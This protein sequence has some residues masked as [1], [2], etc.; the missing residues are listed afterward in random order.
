ML[1]IILVPVLGLVL[2]Y[3]I[4]R[5]FKNAKFKGYDILPFFFI[6]VCNTMTNLKDRPSFLPY[7]FFTFFILVIVLTLWEAIKDK[8]IS[9]SKTIYKLWGYLSL[10]SIMW[11]V[12]LF[13]MTLI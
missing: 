11:Y 7:G 4:N 5:F 12:G 13:F 1:Y 6:P 2:A 10:C 9:F 3:L 8:N